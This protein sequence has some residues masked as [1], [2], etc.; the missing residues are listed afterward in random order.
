[1][2]EI[3]T[4]RLL[5]MID[6]GES[7]V[8]EF[9][10]SFGDAA[11]ETI[12][13]FSNTHG[14]TL[15]I[16]VKDS[17]E[18]SGVQIGKKTLEDIANRIVEATDPRIQPSLSTIQ[19]GKKSLIIVLVTEG[20]SAPISVR[21]RYFR[22]SGRTNQRMSHEEIMQR[23]TTS[24]GVSWDSFIEPGTTL[25]NLDSERIDRFVLAVNKVG[26]RPVPKQASDYE[27]LRK[28]ELIREGA[29]TRAAL[30]L[31]GKNPESYFPSAFLKMGRFR[32]PTLIVDDREAHGTLFDQLD[33]AISWF[34][35]RLETAFIISGNP[36]REVRWEY[37]LSAIREAVTNVLCHRDYTSHAHSQIRLYDDRLEIW[38]AGSLPSSLTPDLLLREH[39]SIPRNR[40]VAEAFFFAGLI[41]R[42]GSGTLRMATELESVGM[43]LPTFTSESGRFRLT[44]YREIFGEE[45][46]RNMGLSERQLLA[47]SYVKEHETISNTEY[48]TVAGVSKRTATRE[49]GELKLKNVLILEGEG[50]RGTVYRIKKH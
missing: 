29:P 5:E 11:L 1:M 37:P 45:R 4:T 44:F 27:F 40:K 8:V 23:M 22:R 25:D 38:N 43:P 41:E 17:G 39:D 50:G 6:A 13:A 20:T 30:L 15:L 46:L 32:S 34:R 16:G 24:M 2:L 33:E 18:I 35:E 10:E 14:G 48:Q 19:H 31:F 49:L 28:M 36:E 3:M 7:E 12:G 9:K 26:R 21:G 47:V 42:W